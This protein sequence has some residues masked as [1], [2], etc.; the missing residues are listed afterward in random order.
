MEEI[1]TVKTGHRLVLSDRRNGQLSGV[2]DV[3]S[4][5]LNEI[6]LE[7]ELGLLTITGSDLHVGRLNLEK[8]E[9]DLEGQVDGFHY[10]DKDGGLKSSQSLLSRLLR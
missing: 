7:T 6:V 9:V 10:S 4:F 1:K 3:R 5:D 2:R 8:G